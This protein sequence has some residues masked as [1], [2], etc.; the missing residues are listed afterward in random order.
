M[1]FILKYQE[2]LSLV[3]RWIK[4][5]ISRHCS[6]SIAWPGYPDRKPVEI[7]THRYKGGYEI[8][9]VIYCEG[10]TIGIELKETDL[11]KALQQAIERRKLFDYFYIAIDLH[12]STIMLMLRS[13]KEFLGHGIGIVST[14][15]NAVIIYSYSKGHLAESKRYTDLL[16]YMGGKDEA[17]HL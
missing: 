13:Y 7:A 8:D 12:V 11:S 15:D 5:L 14:R 1:G 6:N 3:P 16:D 17:V 2:D 4:V 9:A 10:K